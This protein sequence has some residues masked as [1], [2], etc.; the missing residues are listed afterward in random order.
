MEEKRYKIMNESTTSW[1]IIDD[2]AQNLTKEECDKWI[3]KLLNAGA[4]DF[5]LDVGGDIDVDG[6][7][8]LD[9]VSIAGVTSV[10]SLTS[11]RV[12]TV[13]S[14]GKLQDSNNLTFD[15]TSLFV[16]GINVTDPGTGTT[17]S[18]GANI[19]TGNLKATGVSTFTD[20]DING[21]L[22]VDGHTNLDNV[23]IA[24]VATFSSV[25][26]ANEFSG[27]ASANNLSSGTVPTAR[28]SGNYSI[29]NTG[30]AA[31][32]VVANENADAENF[33]VFTNAATGSQ[34][35]KT[36][37]NLKFNASNG[38]LTA[39]SF[40][41]DGSGLTGVTAEGT[42][43]V[44]K[45]RDNTVGTAGTINFDDSLNVSALSA[46]ITTVGL[47]TN[48]NANRLNVIGISTFN[49]EVRIASSIKHI[50][51]TTTSI[52]FPANLNIS[53]NTNSGERLR[54]G[55]LGQIGLGPAQNYGSDGQVLTSKGSGAA[56]EW[57]TVA[58]S[59]GIT[60]N[61][62]GSFSATAGTPS[63]I[64]T[65]TNYSSDDKV[66]EYTIYVKQGSNYQ[67]QKLLAL[68]D[69]STIHTQQFAIMFNS[70]L[71][72][73]C[74]AIISAGNILLRV[75]PETGVNG[76]ANYRVKREVM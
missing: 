74:D 41:G 50:G 33:I 12:V 31:N 57:S 56:V 72:V 20:V 29:T 13:G 53:F 52:N 42:G 70:S 18:I 61:V 36:G 73:Q 40:I 9:N 15:G 32:I 16:S 45:N 19:V 28:L 3:D 39:T 6:H 10:G 59:V 21:D 63:T 1:V 14:G 17:V 37:S 47:N 2:K 64:D 30:S 46:G 5:N 26:N 48:H 34:A 7:T 4:G 66:I 75:T 54:I 69:G 11:G 22:D 25:V 71:L 49:D 76:S 43:I 27:S 60:T 65:F 8:D 68:V 23:T 35:P 38:R 58:S 44:I 51:D 24:G 62:G 55:A 67:A